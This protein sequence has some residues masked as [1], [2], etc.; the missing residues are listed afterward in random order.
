MTEQWS[1]TLELNEKQGV[2][3]LVTNSLNKKQYIGYTS[4]LLNDRW[5]QHWQVAE[6]GRGWVLQAAIRKHGKE[7]FVIEAITDPLPESSLPQVE[8]LYIYLYKT[9]A[10]EGGYNV[11][12]GGDG[13]PCTDEMRRKMSLSGLK[14]P[15]MTEATRRKKREYH[16]GRKRP[17]EWCASIGDSKRGLK[18][19]PEH[20]AKREATR[21]EN[22]KTRVRKPIS[23]KTRELMSLAKKGKPSPRV[24]WK[25]SEETKA[26][27]GQISKS[28]PSAIAH[29]KA[30]AEAKIGKPS[31]NRG[32]THSAE[33]K[34]KFRAGW[35]ARREARL[36]EQ[37]A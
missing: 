7:N 3:Y 2:V 36:P 8:V 20:I 22:D 16:T 4:Q 10:A 31:P 27:I 30:L 24:G 14:K 25:H 29:R 33:S 15:P 26:L 1:F 32:R 12:P 11:T 17:P 19:S 13:V 6:A 5:K 34:A 9:L 21:K 18:H 23:D 37:A 28:N 35:A